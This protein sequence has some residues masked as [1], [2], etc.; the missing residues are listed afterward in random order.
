MSE[1]FAPYR[2][3]HNPDSVPEELKLDDAWVCCDEAKVPL[4]ATRSGAVYAA[5]STN[6]STWRSYDDAYNAWLENEWSYTGIG[7]VI[8]AEEDLVGVDLDKCL[9]Q[10]DMSTR[11]VPSEVDT[12]LSLPRGISPG[13]DELSTV[14]TPFGASQT[15]S[16]FSVTPWAASILERLDSYAEVS[17]S[18][19]GVKIW[20]E[21]PSITRAHVKPGLEIYPKG[22]YFTV[23]G[24]A[25]SGAG[26]TISNRDEELA[27]I[28]TEEF[29]KVDR[30]RR[31][32]D[33]P[34]KVL[35]LLDYLEKANVEIYAELSDGSAE[36]VY[37]IRCL[38]ADDHSKETS[39]TSTRVG[40]YPDGATWYRCEHAHCRGFRGWRQ[41]RAECDPIVHLG[42]PRRGSGRLR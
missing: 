36:R 37:A 35:D 23:T 11:L 38:W 8:R 6:E 28:V 15:F 14:S 17:P 24:L 7:R 18:L 29:P 33:G 9:D 41:F 30:D 31:E 40:Q 21:A 19:T 12:L 26:K 4:V 2:F 25:L 10:V 34:Q 42:R 32:Y 27:T 13:S 39:S 5:S 16:F 1:T 20:V 22:R 3:E